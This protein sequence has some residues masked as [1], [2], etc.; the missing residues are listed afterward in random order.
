SSLGCDGTWKPISLYQMEFDGNSH[1]IH[2]TDG[3]ENC[4]LNDAFFDVLYESTVKDLTLNYN[5][6]GD[7]SSAFAKYISRSKVSNISVN[8]MVRLAKAVLGESFA[9]VNGVAGY[10]A[11]KFGALAAYAN[12]SDFEKI[13]F[14]G[15]IASEN[16]GSVT[17]L[18]PLIGDASV[19]MVNGASVTLDELNCGASVCAGGLM[20]SEKSK[21]QV[22]GLTL[23]AKR[24]NGTNLVIGI[25][26]HLPDIYASRA[27]IEKL[28]TTGADKRVSALAHTTS[29][30][31]QNEIYDVSVKLDEVTSAGDLSAMMNTIQA[32]ISAYHLEIGK[33][34]SAKTFYTINAF[35]NGTKAV[36]LKNSEFEV[37]AYESEAADFVA[38]IN[39][40]KMANIN[41]IKVT[42]GNIK[43][44]DIYAAN[45]S[46][47]AQSKIANLSVESDQLDAANNLIAFVNTLTDSSIV[48]SQLRFTKA[49][50]AKNVMVINK[51]SGSTIEYT[52]VA[53]DE[54]TAETAHF[55][56][57]SAKDS[58][59]NIAIYANPK[60][61][62]PANDLIV[63]LSE[64]TLDDIVSM[65]HQS[66]LVEGSEN[67]EAV[68]DHNLGALT[69][70]N[71]SNVWWYQRADDETA[72][73]HGGETLTA[74][75]FDKSKVDDV[76][77]SLTNWKKKSFAEDSANVDLP[78][79]D[80]KP[81]PP[82]KPEG[83]E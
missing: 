11:T 63:K 42:L 61:K 78:W 67:Y 25:S 26:G 37:K 22:A 52:G 73:A 8:G 79:P 81:V 60:V 49:N 4:D 53:F 10:N 38:L 75:A 13:L 16:S 45:N 72:Q 83:G 27:H 56:N 48:D 9:T 35:G 64:S 43:A 21:A 2:F 47:T 54:L 18:A 6:R 24:I 33:A 28:E 20:L 59:S 39:A 19:I 36:S 17:Q 66:K 68:K 71:A 69:A 31:A 44:K 82:E 34:K 30:I 29:A 76:I 32:D 62:T 58:W 5:I 57:D 14:S 15:A 46:V 80:K 7:V 51:S 1:V 74:S 70:D 12:Y 55:L 65:V 50:A 77:A 23:E 40:A 41:D 3:K